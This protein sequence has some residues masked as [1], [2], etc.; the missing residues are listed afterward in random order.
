MPEGATHR[1]ASNSSVTQRPVLLAAVR[2]FGAPMRHGP[3]REARTGSA[4]RGIIAWV[5]EI[6][7]DE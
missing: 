5:V 7:S 6:Q 1:D 3:S 2:G 4:R